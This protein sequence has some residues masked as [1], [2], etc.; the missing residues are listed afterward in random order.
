MIAH[1]MRIMIVNYQKV[2]FLNTTN[3]TVIAVNIRRSNAQVDI[4]ISPN[5]Y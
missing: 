5:E 3:F 1:A 4:V 2:L